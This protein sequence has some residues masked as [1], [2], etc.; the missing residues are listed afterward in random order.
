MQENQSSLVVHDNTNQQ[1]TLVH[2]FNPIKCYYRTRSS[3][4]QNFFSDCPRVDISWSHFVFWR[5]CKMSFQLISNF[6][7]AI[8]IYFHVSPINSHF[9]SSII[10]SIWL[11]TPP[12]PHARRSDA[13]KVC[14]RSSHHRHSDVSTHSA[15]SW[16]ATS[17]LSLGI[18]IRLY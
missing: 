16:I 18:S 7:F 9:V 15:S 4:Y 1:A 14:H 12:S 17:W 2:R 13:I 11:R 5:Y 3:S 10:I 8:K 6:N